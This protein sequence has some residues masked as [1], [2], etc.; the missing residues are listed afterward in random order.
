TI[1]TSGVDF[2]LVVYGSE[3]EE[4]PSR[5]L[6]FMENRG[7]REFARLER[8]D[9]EELDP[10]KVV[11][12]SPGVQGF[13]LARK[14]SDAKKKEAGLKEVMEQNAG[15]TLAIL[16][17]LELLPVMAENAAAQDDI[18]AQ[19]DKV[20]KS[21]ADYGPEMKLQA[22]HIVAQQFVRMDNLPDLAIDYAREGE[23]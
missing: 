7:Q 15:Q 23:K 5:L 12:Q 9:L 10:Q 2:A 8:T 18:R 16:A 21:A 22:T 3:K 17:G 14:E 1:Q 13:L 19:A 6:G 11:V 20:I 4:A